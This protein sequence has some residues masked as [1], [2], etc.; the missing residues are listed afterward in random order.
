[1]YKMFESYKKAIPE[2]TIYDSARNQAELEQEKKKNDELEQQHKIDN[3]RYYE[4][5]EWSGTVQ[6]K[7]LKIEK[8]LEAQEGKLISSDES[9]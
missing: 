7:L 5:K 3:E 4:V 1:M 6:S 9:Q 8:Q 2:L